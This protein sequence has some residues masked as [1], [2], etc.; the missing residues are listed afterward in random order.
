[1]IRKGR[2]SEEKKRVEKCDRVDIGG[3]AGCARCRC[4]HGQRLLSISC[5]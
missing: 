5:D 4:L 3:C 1:M 2:N